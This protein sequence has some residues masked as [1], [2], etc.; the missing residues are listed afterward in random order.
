MITRLSADSPC[1]G[2]VRRGERLEAI[3]GRRIEDVFDYMHH[4]ASRNPVLTLSGARGVR[5]VQI[6]KPA[7]D[8]LGLAFDSFIMDEQRSCVN[9]CIFCFVDQLP[10][11]MRESL[12]Y[13]DDDARLSYLMGNYIS[14]TNLSERDVRRIIKYRIHPIQVSVHTTDRELRSLLLGNSLGG[15]SLDVL[16]R[17]AQAGLSLN[18]QIVVCKGINDGDSLS[19]TLEDLLALE[20][21]QSIAVVPV[22]LTAHRKGLFPLTPLSSEDAADVCA[23]VDAAGSMA[24][25]RKGR[26]TVYPSDEMLV[27]AQLPIPSAEHYED[28]P[29]L[30]DGVGMLALFRAEAKHALLYAQSPNIPRRVSAITGMAAHSHIQKLIDETTEKCD[31]LSVDLYA[32]ENSFFGNSITVSGLL[33]GGDVYKTLADQ[34]L[35]DE[36]LIPASMLRYD[37]SCFLDDMSVGR[38]EGLLGIPIRVVENNGASLIEALAGCSLPVEAHE[39]F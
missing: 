24:L 4:S 10:P 12:Y 9:N 27:L 6:F 35:G 2:R 28:F 31:N 17:F 1:R 5:R 19:K 11:G 25:Q 16:Y 3:N 26:R 18:C 8:D 22:G 38:L 15:G 14:L 39:L 36:L 32:I 30:E 34:T 37:R 13:K 33:T 29:Q 23:R 20:A 21:T 7:Y